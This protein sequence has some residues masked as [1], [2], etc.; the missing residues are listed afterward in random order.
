MGCLSRQTATFDPPSRRAPWCTV[1]QRPTF[2]PRRPGDALPS[3]GSSNGNAASCPST[4]Q[5]PRLPMRGRSPSSPSNQVT[6]DHKSAAGT[7]CRK[8]G[9]EKAFAVGSHIIAARLVHSRICPGKVPHRGSG[10]TGRPGRQDRHS[11]HDTVTV[12]GSTSS[13]ALSPHRLRACAGRYIARDSAVGRGNDLDE[14]TSTALTR[15]RQ[16]VPP[17]A[18]IR[19]WIGSEI[20]PVGRK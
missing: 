5:F 7:D 15:T 14:V 6:H 12:R 4:W 20:E 16:I 8:E 13:S 1:H 11:R 17:P 10:R 19:R 3:V 18:A 2:V 9:A